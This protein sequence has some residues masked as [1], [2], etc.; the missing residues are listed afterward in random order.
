MSQLIVHAGDFTFLARFEDLRSMP[1]IAE[2]AR[3][4]WMIAEALDAPVL[5]ARALAQ[6][7]DG[8]AE[9]VP[10]LFLQPSLRLIACRW[11]ALE[12]WSAHQAGGNIEALTRRA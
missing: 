12:I 9:T 4:E 7:D 10:E 6:F 1:F 3:L 5:P 8:E 11:P 2:T